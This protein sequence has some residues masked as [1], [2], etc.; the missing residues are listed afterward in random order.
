MGDSTAFFPFS[1]NCGWFS[2]VLPK[3]CGKQL[4]QHH[5]QWNTSM[6]SL[7]SILLEMLFF[8]FEELLYDDE[9]KSKRSSEN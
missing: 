5:K 8:L 3:N 9:K 1:P 2:C 6:I 4:W 7:H